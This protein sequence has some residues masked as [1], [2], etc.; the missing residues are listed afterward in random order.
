M[1]AAAPAGMPVYLLLQEA[2]GWRSGLGADGSQAV[3]DRRRGAAGGRL[4]CS[5]AAATALFVRIA[6]IAAARI[7]Y[8]G[9][10]RGA[11]GEEG[12][13]DGSGRV[14]ESHA[15]VSAV[16]HVGLPGRA[17][18]PAQGMKYVWVVV[19]CFVGR[20]GPG[21]R[22]EGGRDVLPHGMPGCENPWGQRMAELR[23]WI[24]T[25]RWC[26]GQR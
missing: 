2:R 18:P 5:G 16:I 26:E 12:G 19:G 9:E 17:A 20:G 8:R 21:R 25:G 1:G 7:S 10:L 6:G 11:E 13:I 22:Q 23:G 15:G 3:G 14:V 24:D 4:A